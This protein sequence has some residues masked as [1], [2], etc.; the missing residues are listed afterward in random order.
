M[1][2]IT[3]LSA[4]AP[5][6]KK[7]ARKSQPGI[8]GLVNLALMVWMIW[9]IRHRTDEELN[10]K[11]KLWYFAAFAPPIGPIVYFVY[12]RKRRTQATGLPL[13]IAE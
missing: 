2:E 10:G 12:L 1:T 11:R 4:T 13:E 7:R 8:S 9:D 3:D 6:P 5:T